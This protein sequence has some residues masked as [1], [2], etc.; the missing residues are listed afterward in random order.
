LGVTSLL[1]LGLTA[2]QAGPIVGAQGS[3]DEKYEKLADDRRA[4]TQPEP[5][6]AGEILTP[7]RRG[8]VR[9]GFHDRVVIDLRVDPKR[10]S[11]A[12]PLADRFRLS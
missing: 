5:S 12:G 8:A 4:A 7:E 1:Q 3:F 6:A 9:D 2:E 11:E 10:P